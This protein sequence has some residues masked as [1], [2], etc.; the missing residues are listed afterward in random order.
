[1]KSHPYMRNF[2]HKML[3]YRNIFTQGKDVDVDHGVF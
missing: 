3:F 2:E 1:M